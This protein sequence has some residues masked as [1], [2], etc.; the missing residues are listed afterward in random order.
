MRAKQPEMIKWLV[1]HIRRM[2]AAFEPH[3]GEL[4]Q[5][6]RTKFPKT[7]SKDEKAADEDA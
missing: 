5:V 6:L 7:G 4:R 1:D 3:I 2:E